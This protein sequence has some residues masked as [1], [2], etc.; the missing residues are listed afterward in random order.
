MLNYIERG[1]GPALVLMHAFP[2]DSSMWR[3]QLDF[4][5]TRY[6]VITPDIIGFGG[7]QPARPWTMQQMGDEVVALLDELNIERCSLAGLSMGGYVSLPFTFAHPNRVQRLVLAHT[8]A[9][10]DIDTER[11]ARNAMIEE[12]K[13]N[14]VGSLPDK[15]LPR[16]LGAAA[17]ESVRNVVRASILK[18]TAEA[19]IHAVTA[20]R[21]RDDQTTG[22][23]RLDCPTLVIAGSGDA[24]LK[25]EDC[26]AMAQAIPGAEF[27]VIPNT[28]HLSNLEDPTAFNRAVDNFLRQSDSE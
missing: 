18:T 20:M 2:L 3:P 12:L 15:M 22:L 23:G 10:A 5:A 21:D 9:R 19:N 11:A 27:V 4:F 28:G 7:S 26:Q 14:G 6:R 8:R 1:Q 17:S 13:K 16:L 24:I 25:V